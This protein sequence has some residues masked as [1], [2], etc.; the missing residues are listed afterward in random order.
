MKHLGRDRVGRERGKKPLCELFVQHGLGMRLSVCLRDVLVCRQDIE[1]GKH[2]LITTLNGLGG[3]SMPP[4]LPLST[5]LLRFALLSLCQIVSCALLTRGPV[6]IPLH[7]GAP[8][9]G[10]MSLFGVVSASLRLRVRGRCLVF[11]YA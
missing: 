9:N 3:G 6:P 5:S 8:G 1:F 7:V 10:K 2:G 4:F 11:V